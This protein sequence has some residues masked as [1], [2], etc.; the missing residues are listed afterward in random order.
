[1]AINAT[2]CR[3][4]LNVSDMDRGYYGAHNL[5]LAK[6]PSETDLRF[7]LRIAVFAKYAHEHLTFGKGLSS[8][9]EPDLWQ[10]NLNG[11]IERWIDLGQPSDKRLRKACGKS[12]DVVVVSYDERAA[13]MWWQQEQSKLTRFKNLTVLQAGNADALQAL[14]ELA[15]RNMLL[16]ATIQ[17][18]ELWLGGDGDAVSLQFTERN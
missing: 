18:G 8:E 4:E 10:N 11:T 2:I 17:D 14:A 3:C 13:D 16:T 6:H 15:D 7:M 5:T 9:D 12:A 1:M